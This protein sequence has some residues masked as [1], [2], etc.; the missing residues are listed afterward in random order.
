[1]DTGDTGWVLICSALVL[2]MTPG[3]AFFYGGLVRR[4]SV[5][6][7]IMHSFMSMAI[8]GVVWV[9]WGYSLAFAPDVGSFIGNLDYIGLRGVSAVEAGPYSDTIPHM[10]FMIFQ[11]MFA[12]ITPA[13]ITGA[14][15]ERMKFSAY[16]IFV[17][18]WVTIV[19]A[20]MAHWVWGGGW[21]G[22]AG[23]LDF[24][25]GAVVHMNSGVAALVAAM[26]VGKRL[27]HG[28]EPMDSHNVPFVVLGAALLWFGWFGFNAGSALTSGGSATLAFVVTN[29][30]AAAAALTWI[31][32]SWWLSGK[33]SAVGAASGAVAGLVAI[34]P[35]AGFVG[36]MPAIL[37][38]MGAGGLCFAAVNVVRRLKID[39]SL[40]VFAVHGIGGTWGALATG[41]FVG[42]GTAGAFAIG[43]LGMDTRVAQIGRQLLS[44]VVTWGW[45]FTLTA[46][47]LFALKYTIGLRVDDAVEEQGLDLAIHGDEAY[48]A[49]SP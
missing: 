9:L 44:I 37:I 8:V 10:T 25:G 7:V 47:I 28:L 12:I 22:G 38:G 26:I 29:T 39:D 20:P 34:T 32:L 1:M 16:I 48:P 45:S 30:A 21:L 36:P 24:A 49:G 13:L 3:L 6:G 18:A 14:F 33:A 19:Y 46:A 42:V 2:L 41:L 40:D 4:K 17:I 27:R 15:V 35:A 43:D 11:A 31:G 23:A 5:V